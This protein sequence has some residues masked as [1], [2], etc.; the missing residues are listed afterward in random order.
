MS[1]KALQ[2]K[3]RDFIEARD[4][5]MALWKFY[6]T[7]KHY[8]SWVSRD[9]FQRKFNIGVREISKESRQL[10]NEPSR[11]AVDFVIGE[12]GG[13][14]FAVGSRDSYLSLPDGDTFAYT[15]IELMLTGRVVMALAF[16]VVINECGDP[17]PVELSDVLEFHNDPNIQDLF[18]AFEE[19][20]MSHA[21]RRSQ[22]AADDEDAKLA[23]KFTF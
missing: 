3:A 7:V 20:L 5:H 6:D 13:V 9:D 21:A 22:L 15:T 11:E 16:R 18:K 19:A 17:R 10:S 1:N 4:W 14:R 23:G 2:A 12:L 8:P